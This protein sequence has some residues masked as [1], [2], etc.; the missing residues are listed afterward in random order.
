VSDGNA[1]SQATQFY[2]FT[3]P[4][5]FSKLDVAAIRTVKYCKDPELKRK[6]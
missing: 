5:A 2:L 3:G 1:R 6:K 4:E